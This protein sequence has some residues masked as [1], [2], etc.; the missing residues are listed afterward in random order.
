MAEYIERDE[1]V[2]KALEGC[3]KVVGHGITQIE[4]VDIADIIDSIPTADVVPVVRCLMCE[5]SKKLQDPCNPERVYRFC[6]LNQGFVD[7]NDY[8]SS[9]RKAQTVSKTEKVAKMDG[10]RW[11]D[12]D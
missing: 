8:C 12:N 6:L 1:A 5:N 7:S 4:A 9:G 10:E 3:V 11:C 2:R